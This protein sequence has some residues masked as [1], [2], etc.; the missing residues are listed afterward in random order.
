M[1][2]YIDGLLRRMADEDTEVR[3]RAYDE[4]KELDDLLTFPYLQQKVTK[5]K[6]IAMKKD[7]YYVM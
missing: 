3:H 7:M 2:E 1:E 5:A 4:A 6:K